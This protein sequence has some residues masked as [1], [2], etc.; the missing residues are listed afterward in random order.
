MAKSSDAQRDLAGARAKEPPG[1]LHEIAEI[2]E[3][4]EILER[5]VADVV[6]AQVELNLAG[7][8]SQVARRR[9]CP[10]AGG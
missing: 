7:A 2:V 8:V 6:A 10:G 1:R 4:Q 3:L 5:F 9:S